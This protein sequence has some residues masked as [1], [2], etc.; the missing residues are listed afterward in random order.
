MSDKEVTVYPTYG[1]KRET[2]ENTWII[3]MRVWVHK[4]RR[5]PIPDDAVRLLL[6][7]EGD[8]KESEVIRCRSCLEDFIADDDSLETVSFR[9]D[10][11]DET[12]SFD[13]RTDTNGLVAQQFSL[14]V[15]KAKELLAKQS[16][17]DWLT[18]KAEVEGFTGA[19]QIRLLE[20]EGL[21]VVSDIDDTIKVS[22]IPAGEKIVL[23]NTF[24]REYVVAPGMLDKYRS[25]G[26]VSFHYISGSPW[27]LFKLLHTFLIEKSGFPK[28]TFHMKSLSKNLLNLPLF[29]RD[30]R[31]FIAGKEYTKK[32]KIEQITE[33]MGNLPR[34]RFILIGDSGEL[35][36]EVF[37]EIRGTFGQ[38]VEKIVI[39]DVVD[40][41]RNAPERLEGVDEVITAPLVERNKSQFI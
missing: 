23:R 1:F 13:K 38:R 25:F 5:T 9:F 39:R 2:D 29:I 16:A 34:R 14:P 20:P 32:Q 3:P 22:E 18:V 15:E 6:D 36:P 35:D 11:D 31:N 7:D 33:L 4:K 27:Q 8:L 37:R 19:G 41:K 21:S 17:S 26:D 40:A 10:S 24:L 12:Y 30:I 28:G